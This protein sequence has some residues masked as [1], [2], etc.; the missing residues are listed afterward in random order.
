MISVSVII[1]AYNHQDFIERAVQSV[2]NQSTEFPLDILL[3]YSKSDDSTEEK[4]L[5]LCEMNSI[6]RL[7][8]LDHG[9]SFAENTKQLIAKLNSKYLIV[10]DGDDYWSNNLKLQRQVNFLEI[11]VDY[12]GVFHDVQI[13]NDSPILDANGQFHYYHQF[14]SFSQFNTYRSDYF[15]WDAVSRLIIPPGSLLIRTNKFQEHLQDLV[16]VEYSG[17]WMMTLYVLK[18][19]KFRYINEQWSIYRNHNGGITKRRPHHLFIKS[20]IQVLR[21]LLKDSYYK[22]IRWNVYKSISKE[23]HFLISSDSIEKRKDR[24]IYFFCANYYYFRYQLIQIGRIMRRD[25]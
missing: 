2:L 17:G 19:S 13:M 16:L 11:N 10:M 12:N 24:I 7:I 14:K 9:K 4:A 15:P 18:Y 25:I 21:K 1:F 5:F 23:Y 3:C 6:I 8:Y 20:N 22:S